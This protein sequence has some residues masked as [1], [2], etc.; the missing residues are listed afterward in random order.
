MDAHLN[1]PQRP[2]GLYA[3]I[4][5]HAFSLLNYIFDLVRF[6]IGLVRIPLPNVENPLLVAAFH[7]LLIL[8]LIVIIVGL[9]Q[10]RYWAWYAT[11][12]L[13]GISL[14]AGI[15]QYFHGGSPYVTLAFSAVIVF[16]L[17]QREVRRIFEPHAQ[18]A[19]VEV[20]R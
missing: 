1:T 4:V 5:L 15:W 13:T 11:M 17:N 9:W 12:V 16:Y 18:L 6:Q 14:I 2:F 20:M 19:E 10:L 7:L 3:I 8:L